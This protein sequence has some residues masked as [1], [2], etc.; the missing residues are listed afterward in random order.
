MNQF[1]NQQRSRQAVISQMKLQD[2]D[3]L[4]FKHIR[5]HITVSSTIPSGLSFDALQ[6]DGTN[7]LNSFSYIP[8]NMNFPPNDLQFVS[9]IN[10]K[11][12]LTLRSFTGALPLLTY[13][14]IADT[15]H[16]PHHHATCGGNHQKSHKNSRNC[17]KC[18]FRNKAGCHHT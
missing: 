9:S 14:H 13:L 4:D 17:C 3:V 11:L 15:F 16:A 5:N 7:D 2:L 12:S 8:S 10:G 6:N 18:S 1:V